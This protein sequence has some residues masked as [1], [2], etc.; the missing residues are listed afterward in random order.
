MKR[1]LILSILLVVQ[2]MTAQQPQ[3]EWENPTI[4]DRNKEAGR[5]TFVLYQDENLATTNKPE[6]SSYYK[7]L[8]GDWKFNIVKKTA[9]RPQDFYKT[10]LDD[11]NWKNISVPS[12]WE[13]QGFDIPIYTNITYPF[14]KNPPFVNNEYNPVGSYRKTFTVPGNWTGK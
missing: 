6:A 2:F 1:K 9:D 7:S 5:A 8:N 3:N 4:I 14:P 12:N 10:D 11:K 13:M